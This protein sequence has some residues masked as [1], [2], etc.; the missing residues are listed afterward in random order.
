M[1]IRT[2]T[3]K[4]TTHKLNNEVLDRILSNLPVVMLRT[5]NIYNYQN[6]YYQSTTVHYRV[7][8]PIQ[9][10]RV[11]SFVPEQYSPKKDLWAT[12]ATP[13]QLA[14][15]YTSFSMPVVPWHT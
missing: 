14:A 3:T 15:E 6:E 4:I 13:L 5:S 2:A 7:G 9:V 8:G 10:G 12:V 11:V 1:H